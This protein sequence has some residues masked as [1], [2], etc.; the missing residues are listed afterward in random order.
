MFPKFAAVVH[1][2]MKNPLLFFGNQLD[3]IAM[4]LGQQ[5]DELN[6]IN[7]NTK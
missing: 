7:P 2:P 1:K 3:I 5:R 4:K 6:P